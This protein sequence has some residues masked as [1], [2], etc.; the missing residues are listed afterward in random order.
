MCSINL[1]L[2]IFEFKVVHGHCY[3][4]SFCDI[5]ANISKTALQNF[6]HLL[7]EMEKRMSRNKRKKTHVE[8]CLRF[9]DIG[10]RKSGLK[11]TRIWFLG[12]CSIHSQCNSVQ[13]VKLHQIKL[14]FDMIQLVQPF[15]TN[16]VRPSRPIVPKTAKN[17]PKHCFLGLFSKI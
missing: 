13:M 2:E 4:C 16:R 1:V 15:R 9:R 10:P 14:D 8:S 3:V 6:S 5:S 12:F 11:M 17:G 7:Y